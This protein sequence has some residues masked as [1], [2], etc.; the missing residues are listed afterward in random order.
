MTELA[1]TRDGYI[2]VRAPQRLIDQLDRL[3]EH[4]LISRSDFV[5]RELL[6]AVR[7]ADREPARA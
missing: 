3:A 6:L 1:D 7:A 4:E 5:R 2:T